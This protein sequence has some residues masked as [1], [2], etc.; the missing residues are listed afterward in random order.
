MFEDE[1]YLDEQ[2]ES[3]GSNRQDFEDMYSDYMEG[4]KE[5][6]GVGGLFGGQ[7][8]GK[9]QLYL[10]LIAIQNSF[11]AWEEKNLA[12]GTIER[13]PTKLSEM[14]TGEKYA[15]TYAFKLKSGATSKLTLN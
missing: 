3:S 14:L 10:K 7:F 6:Q 13:V 2:F 9:L 5:Q 1:E 11:N 8:A 4:A 12:K 15:G